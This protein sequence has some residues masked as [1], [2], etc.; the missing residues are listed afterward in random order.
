MNEY[1]DHILDDIDPRIKIDD[2]QRKV[3][4]DASKNALVIA[5]AG[6][7]KSTTIAAKVKY[8]VDKKEIA[9]EKILIM[10]YSRKSVEDLR[11]KINIEL[12]IPADVTTFH[13]L[14]FRYLRNIYA[15]KKHCFVIDEYKKQD[16]FIEFLKE[17]I[18]T[19][20]NSFDRFYQV[21]NEK[22]PGFTNIGNNLYGNFIRENYL[23]YETFDQ[24]FTAFIKHKVVEAEN[25][26]IINRDII[27]SR[28]NYDTP[29]TI[30]GE[31][32]KSKAE[33]RIANYLFKLGID[34]EYEKVYSEIL[35]DN[36]T[37]KPDFTLNIAGEEVYLEYFGLS[38]TSPKYD[39]E[40]KRKEEHFNAKF[41]K[42]I[43]LEPDF[44]FSDL[45]KRLEDFGF[46]LNPR[47]EAEI[48]ETLL[49]DNPLREFYWLYKT[50]F[51]K[52]LDQILSSKDRT[53][54]RDVISDYL[55]A[56]NCTPEE[57][58]AYE[59]QTKY[60]IEFYDFYKSKTN[61]TGLI[62]FDYGDL[63]LLPTY[64]LPK[65]KTKIFSYE[66]II[67]DEYQDISRSRYD[68]T[69]A[70]LK[71]TD[72]HFLAVGD[73]WQT[74][75][76][77][78]GSKISYIRDFKKYFGED[79]EI[80]FITNTYRNGPI[81]A[82]SSGE[83]V[84]KNPDQIKKELHSSRRDPLAPIR[85]AI[86]D[87]D[88]KLQTEPE[89]LEAFVRF[90]HRQKPNDSILVLARTNKI[91]ENIIKSNPHFS[92][93]KSSKRVKVKGGASFD[94]LT[95][96]ASKGMTSDWTIL[97]GMYNNFPLS[98][99]DEFWLAELFKEK[100]PKERIRDAE[101]RRL[102][103]VALT[104]TRNSAIILINKNLKY[105]SPFIAELQEILNTPR[106]HLK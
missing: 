61:Q 55:H 95:M 59:L 21:F 86:Y 64:F 49:K 40:R 75:Y 105:R 69:R 36:A 106:F 65:T 24:Y 14:G 5:G 73:D 20:S 56:I 1:L 2:E 63:I 94:F 77:F 25:F 33:A 10:S 71:A 17:K 46:K 97:V 22:S 18:Y 13:S 66:Y 30:R 37:Y 15:G 82:G 43:A 78:Q 74:I 67:V 85:F 72:A 16:I 23:K 51:G 39:A 3:V 9:P 103:Y 98:D 47:S 70:I 100:K 89:V 32:V 81:V 27:E 58:T 52:V 12:N 8:L 62:G 68:F 84:M 4:L 87:N 11:N 99:H 101:E 53:H 79:S 41:Q 50:V 28:L 80:Y 7:G 45:R 19:S 54:F 34:Y 48:Y 35:V 26:T 88:S 57:R 90:I 6:T 102:F 96:H 93:D 91:I 83:F 31:Y 29:M 92:S 76:S 60:F 44:K 42:F 104:R 38:G